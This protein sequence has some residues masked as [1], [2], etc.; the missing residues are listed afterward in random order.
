M[1]KEKIIIGN[2]KMSPNSIEE[3]KKIIS[4][5]K[6]VARNLKGVKLVIAPPFSFLSLV[7]RGI[8][9]DGN[10]YLGAQDVSIYTEGAH[11]GE[12]SVSILKGSG[13][14]YCIIGHS[15]RRSM[16]ENND[17]VSE[18]LNIT[19]S[20]NITPVLCVGE[21][22]RDVDGKYMDFLKEQISLS[23]SKINKKDI[24][25]IIL[26]YEPVWAIGAKEP[27]KTEE[28]RQTVL[29]IRKIL[30]DMSDHKTAFQVPILYGGAVNMRNAKEIISYGDVNGLLIGRESL[31]PIGFSALLKE[32]DSL[33]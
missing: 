20:N 1:K 8:E 5:S 32:V 21:K 27:M 3:A 17:I 22:E 18:K 14:K 12:V 7:L 31:N 6:K 19:V 4:S 23:L 28:I 11:T 30:S 9:K 16:G 15:E 2:W 13:V 10:F 33:N 24:N 25:K 29:Y 26:A